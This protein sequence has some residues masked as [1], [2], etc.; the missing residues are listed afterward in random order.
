MEHQWK[1]LVWHG[2]KIVPHYLSKH[3]IILIRFKSK[4]SNNL[5]LPHSHKLVWAMTELW[6]WYWGRESH[7]HF[8]SAAK[9]LYKCWFLSSS[10]ICSLFHSPSPQFANFNWT[11]SR[12]QGWDKP[13]IFTISEV[14]TNIFSIS[15][16]LYI[17][18][19]LSLFL[20]FS[21]SLSLSLRV[22]FSLC[23]FLPFLLYWSFFS[24]LSM[25]LKQIQ[26]SRIR[27]VHICLKLRSVL[28]RTIHYGPLILSFL[29]LYI[30]VSF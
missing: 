22:L 16:Y 3:N 11:Q 17:F 25:N 15:L 21:L 23:T 18:H 19:S 13:R 10:V 9:I 2:Y 29:L 6:L 26:R 24:F 28:A 30:Q 8:I 5:S 12:Q 4:H 1:V 20:S 7:L 14:K 27:N